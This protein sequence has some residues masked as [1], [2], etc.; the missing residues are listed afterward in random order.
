MI[1]LVGI[2]LI[3]R[4]LILIFEDVVTVSFDWVG[5]FVYSFVFLLGALISSILG[6]ATPILSNICTSSISIVSKYGNWL[7]VSRSP[8]SN[9]QRPWW[10]QQ[11]VIAKNTANPEQRRS[12]TPFMILHMVK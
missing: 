3:L 10:I 11:N 8:I 7:S 5:G 12:N 1:C 2:G 9:S 4:V 6:A